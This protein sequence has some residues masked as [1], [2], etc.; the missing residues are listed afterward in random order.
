M[1][2]KKRM[3]APLNMNEIPTS[4][5]KNTASNKE[6]QELSKAHFTCDP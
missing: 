1:E 3:I 5:T 6:M 4:K 2:K